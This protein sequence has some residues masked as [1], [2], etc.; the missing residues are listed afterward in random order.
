MLGYKM[1]ADCDLTVEF[2]GCER[3]LVALLLAL[4]RRKLDQIV[5]PEGWREGY[6]VL[7]AK[8]F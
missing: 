5:N 1:V 8:S 4:L 6:M 3:L 7:Q 2:A